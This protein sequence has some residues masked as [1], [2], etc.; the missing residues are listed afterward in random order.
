MFYIQGQ[1]MQKGGEITPDWLVIFY[2]IGFFKSQMQI[3]PQMEMSDCESFK[4][5]RKN[6]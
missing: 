4:H 2:V 5:L 1:L 6:I 3:F